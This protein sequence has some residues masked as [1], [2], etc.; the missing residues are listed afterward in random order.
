MTNM[1]HLYL[2]LLSVFNKMSSNILKN[3]ETKGDRT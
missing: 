3:I 2:K 1:P